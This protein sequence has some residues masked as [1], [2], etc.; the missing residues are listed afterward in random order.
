MDQRDADNAE[1]SM[2]NQQWWNMTRRS[3]KDMT[4]MYSGMHRTLFNS[5]SGSSLM[6]AQSPAGQ[7]ATT[8]P[9]P[10]QKMSDLKINFAATQMTY[11]AV[12][13]PWRSPA[14]GKFDDD[15]KH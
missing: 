11:T 5:Q 8:A 12:R 4:T 13:S 1:M 10:V 9:S 2:S 14:R 7:R 3:V 6:Q 15:V